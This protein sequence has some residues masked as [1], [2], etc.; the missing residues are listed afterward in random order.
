MVSS[1]D[2]GRV[3]D[4]QLDLDPGR[5]SRCHQVVQGG[6]QS[7]GT[8]VRRVDLDQQRAERPQALPDLGAERLDPL[9]ELGA[10]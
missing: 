3:V 10:V 5:E 1:T 4:L 8:Q 9:G 7:L 2:G 6:R